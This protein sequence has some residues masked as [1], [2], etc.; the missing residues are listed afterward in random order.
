MLKIEKKCV[1][2]TRIGCTIFGRISRVKNV[3]YKLN[4][5]IMIL[6]VFFTFVLVLLAE[7]LKTKQQAWLV[8]LQIFNKLPTTAC[9]KVSFRFSLSYLLN[10]YN[11]CQIRH[12]NFVCQ[13]HMIP[14]D[15]SF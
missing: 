5:L 11:F 1:A 4:V 7:V 8:F 6:F 2:W 9:A 15:L 12:Q 10:Y 13:S 14:F 3:F